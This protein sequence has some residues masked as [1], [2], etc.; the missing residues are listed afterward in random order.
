[1]YTILQSL[2]HTATYAILKEFIQYVCFHI[3]MIKH[4]HTHTLFSLRRTVFYGMTLCTLEYTYP[5]YGGPYCFHL[6]IA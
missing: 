6:L 4:E 3:L 1:M 5:C 2:P